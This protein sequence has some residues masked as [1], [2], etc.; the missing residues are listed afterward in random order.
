MK[1]AP[2]HFWHGRWRS[3]GYALA[4]IAYVWRTQPNFW[5]HTV[6]A[7]FVTILGLVLRLSRYEWAILLLAMIIV[8]SAELM[9][10]AIEAIVDKASPEHHP[11]AKAAKDCAAGAVFVAAIGAVLIGILILAPPLLSRLFIF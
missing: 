4:G 7:V 9:N 10:S 6:M 2:T 5:I 8:F 3:F 11:L 1:P